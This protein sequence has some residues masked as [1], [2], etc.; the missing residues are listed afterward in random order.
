MIKRLNRRKFNEE[1]GKTHLKCSLRFNVYFDDE[2]FKIIF[3]TRLNYKILITLLLPLL[4]MFNIVAHGILIFKETITA[5]IDFM[6]E[7]V[8]KT[9][10]I[11]SNKSWIYERICKVLE[12][13]LK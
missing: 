11:M 12:Y 3:R 10:W 5:Y 2:K 9:E 6:K 1:F 8:Y 4:I 7:D 13:D